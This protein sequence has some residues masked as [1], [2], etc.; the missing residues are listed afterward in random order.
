MSYT[1]TTWH[2]GD[3]LSAEAMNKIE[4][5][6]AGAGSGALEVNIEEDGNELVMDK[7]W[8][9]IYD[10]FPNVYCVALNEDKYIIYR[11]SSDDYTVETIVPFCADGPDDYPYTVSGGSG[12]GYDNIS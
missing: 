7:T 4:N 6:I 3:V 1:P 2:G 12:G 8:Q 10:A 5:G 11:I 9:E